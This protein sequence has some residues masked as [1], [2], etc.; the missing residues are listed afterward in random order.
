MVL[1]REWSNTRPLIPHYPKP[2]NTRGGIQQA[3][4]QRYY[5]PSQ[6]SPS[7]VSTV[8]LLL[9]LI[10]AENLIACWEYQTQHSQAPSSP[11]ALQELESL[12]NRLLRKAQVRQKVCTSIPVE[13]LSYVS[14]AL[15]RTTFTHSL[16]K[17]L[18]FSH[19]QQHWNGLQ[20]VQ[21]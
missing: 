5:V 1:K 8:P 9:R 4:Q 16:T 20:A 15:Q 17:L 10:I 6:F 21:S 3:E 19:K 11:D 7:S 14:L 2:S 18:E 12:A 13:T